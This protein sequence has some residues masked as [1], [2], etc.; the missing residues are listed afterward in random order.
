MQCIWGA[1]KKWHGGMHDR[2][3]LFACLHILSKNYQAISAFAQRPH[4]L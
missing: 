4:S 2:A 1:R 3:H